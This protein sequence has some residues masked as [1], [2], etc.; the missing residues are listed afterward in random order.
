MADTSHTDDRA[1]FSVTSFLTPPSQ[2]LIDAKA[3]S[4][5]K[6]R[7]QA[8]KFNADNLVSQQFEAT[9]SDGTKIP[10]FVVHRSDMKFDGNNPTLLYAY[11]GFEVSSTPTY[12]ASTGKL[13]LERGG[14]QPQAASADPGAADGL[15]DPQADGR[16][17]AEALTF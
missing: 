2:W 10:Y 9:S 5:L 4:A 17:R 8:A 12:G 14:G 16:G 13:W 15:P 7:Q 3:G 1:L 11:G 6:F